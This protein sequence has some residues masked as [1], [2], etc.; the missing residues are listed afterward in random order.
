MEIYLPIVQVHIDIITILFIRFMTNHLDN[1][2]YSTKSSCTEY[3]YTIISNVPLKNCK[4]LAPHINGKCEASFLISVGDYSG[5]SIGWDMSYN[6][7]G[8]FYFN[9]DKK[10]I[11]P[12]KNFYKKNNAVNYLR[13]IN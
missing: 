13:S 6:I 12:L 7:Y 1:K 9:N 2:I 10:F 8:L 4:N 3:S 5:G 11:I